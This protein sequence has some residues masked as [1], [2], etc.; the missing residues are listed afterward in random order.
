MNINNPTFI[1]DTLL[2][3]SNSLNSEE[4]KS[5]DKLF[6]EEEAI[7]GESDDFRLYCLFPK[8]ISIID[9]TQAY[10]FSC[11]YPQEV[12]EYLMDSYNKII[13][14]QQLSSELVSELDNYLH[15]NN[16][17][18]EEADNFIYQLREILRLHV[19]IA[20][21]YKNSNYKL[22]FDYLLT[23]RINGKL[24]FES[25]AAEKISE[26]EKIL[27]VYSAAKDKTLKD[28]PII[29]KQLLSNEAIPPSI[30]K[31]FV[32][33]LSVQIVMKIITRVVKVSRYLSR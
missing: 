28:L 3:L 16:Y 12:K 20:A 23:Y 9:E 31:S 29:Y 13:G 24:L 30:R 11:L 2:N 6:F 14:E 17:F 32:D 19:I 26:L 10:Y 22:L 21:F 8:I 7:I 33:D 18:L 25:N 5:L 15:Q 4:R 1:M 27:A